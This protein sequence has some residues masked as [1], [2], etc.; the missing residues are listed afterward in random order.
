MASSMG[1]GPS[2]PSSPPRAGTSGRNTASV[3]DKLIPTG[4]VEMELAERVAL[5]LWRLRRIARYEAAVSA[6]SQE[7]AE[8]D[9]IDKQEEKYRYNH[10]YVSYAPEAMRQKLRDY[11]A[12]IRL[13]Y[14]RQCRNKHLL[15]RVSTATL[16]R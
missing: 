4:A 1:C 12:R 11:P 14:V 2:S 15:K 9:Y 16:T 13:L 10:V 8:R 6:A 3:A 7:A 5:L